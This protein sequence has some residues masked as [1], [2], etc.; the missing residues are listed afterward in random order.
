MDTTPSLIPGAGSQFIVNF[1]GSIEDQDAL[2]LLT[3]DPTTS[4][5]WRGEPGAAGVQL[6]LEIRGAGSYAGEFTRFT[7]P[8]KF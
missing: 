7:A 8:N 6:D 1:R 5:R 3:I 4:V 2:N